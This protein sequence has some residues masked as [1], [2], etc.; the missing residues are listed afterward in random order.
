MEL[1]SDSQFRALIEHSSDLISLVTEDGIVRYQSP[2]IE[3]ML[4]YESGEF[5]GENVFEYFHPDDRPHV[6][7]AFEK[8]IDSPGLKTDRVEYRFRHE[9]GSW[10]WLESTATNQT[11]TELD[12]YVI[13]SRLI[14]ERKEQERR[15]AEERDKYEALVTNS[16]D[17]IGIIQDVE[18][19]FANPQ[20][21][22]I[23][24][25]E[26]SELI[27]EAFDEIM[28]PGDRDLVRNRYEQ[29]LDPEAKSPPAQ[30][31]VRILTKE[32]DERIVELSAAAIQYEGESADLVTFRD[33]TERK[34]YERALEERNDELEALN[35]L[36]RHDIRNDMAVILGWAEMLEDYIEPGGEESLQKIQASGEHIVELT[37]IARDFVETLVSDADADVS[38]TSLRSIVM[39]ELDLT[40]EAFPDAKFE[41]ACEIPDVEVTANELLGSLFRNILNNAVQHTDKDAPIVVVDCEVKSDVVE[42][43]IADNGP[44]IPDDQKES[45]FGK[46]EKGW[47]VQALVSDC[48]SFKRWSTSTMVG[49]G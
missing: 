22:D 8:A 26:A 10:V 38:P 3:R 35:R 28:A 39:T 32:G 48:T 14:G 2:S 49:F 13:T 21:R 47:I 23:L 5:V 20:S 11:D 25:Y 44:G 12:G 37:K 42:V 15:L 27:G 17:A 1:K 45:I 33:V 30:Y 4:G 19:V 18:Y 24:G 46:G 6:L 36:V 43:R 9:D 34:E 29:R 16:H 41:T 7:E 40:R 31:E